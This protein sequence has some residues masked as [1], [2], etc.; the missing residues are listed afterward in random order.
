MTN[1]NHDATGSEGDQYAED[2]K[3]EFHGAPSLEHDAIAQR[4][5]A[6]S[7]EERGEF[8]MSRGIDTNMEMLKLLGAVQMDCP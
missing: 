7:D 3:E 4:V 8:L 5:L 6:M 2:F 1:I